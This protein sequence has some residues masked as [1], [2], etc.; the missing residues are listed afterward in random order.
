MPDKPLLPQVGEPAPDFSLTD[1][2]GATVNLADFK[3]KQALVLY[4]YPKDDTPGCTREACA[5]RDLG[6]EFA[7]AGAAI[8]GVS[9]QDAKSHTKFTTKYGLNFPLLSD[10]D[11]AMIERYGSWGE[12]V[13]MGNRSMGVLRNTFVI[14]KD[15]V[16]RAVFPSV[17]VDGHADEVLA[18]VKA[19]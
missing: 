10:P 14:D 7:D 2:D 6:S 16:I 19:L 4:F 9:P 17:K 15:G 11:H 12:K 1:G 3:G 8:L 5:F 18:A 13:F